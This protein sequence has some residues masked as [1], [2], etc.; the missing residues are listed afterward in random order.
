VKAQVGPPSDVPYSF[1]QTRPPSSKRSSRGT[2]T[3]SAPFAAPLK[4]I[5]MKLGAL[6]S[7][8]FEDNEMFASRSVHSSLL[9]TRLGAESLLGSLVGGSWL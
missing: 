5:H 4:S 3:G 6:A 9:V 1:A 8:G 2:L 7:R